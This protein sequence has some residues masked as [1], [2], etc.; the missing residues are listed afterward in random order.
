MNRQELLRIYKKRAPACD[1]D[2]KLFNLIGFRMQ[3]YRREAV[4]AQGII[5]SFAITLIPSYDEIIR[6]GAD[7][8]AAGG[9]FVVLDFRLPDWPLWLVK[10]TLKFLVKPFGGSLE[11]A[12][13]HP[14]ESLDRYLSIVSE[15][16]Y[17]FGSTYY[18]AG[19]KG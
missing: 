7:S 19:E 12:E 18:T 15:K 5:T 13:H 17:Y 8:L 2:A 3:K 4:E 9:R 1:F 16:K 6:K 11:M 10:L 14:W